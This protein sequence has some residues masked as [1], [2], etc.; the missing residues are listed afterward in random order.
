MLQL[1]IENKMKGELLKKMEDKSKSMFNKTRIEE[2]E[3]I[4]EQSNIEYEND[5]ENPDELLNRIE[6]M[7]FL[8]RLAKQM[9]ENNKKWNEKL[10]ISDGGPVI[11]SDALELLI[12]S[13]LKPFI[14]KHLKD[15][16][17]FRYIELPMTENI[18]VLLEYNYSGISK[19]YNMY[20]SKD[21]E[22][23]FTIKSLKDLLINSGLIIYFDEEKQ[24]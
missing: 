2:I 3:K 1:K 17:D 5:D 11:V 4:Y 18:S 23:V 24:L 19:L 14:K 16:V 10:E 15:I 22:K 7:E 12:D 6:F 8:M 21:F 13:K 20:L 9:G